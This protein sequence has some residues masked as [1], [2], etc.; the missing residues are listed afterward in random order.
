MSNR[1]IKFAQEFT[2]MPIGRYRADDKFSG[3]VFREDLLVPAL[4]NNNTVTLDLS[5][6][7]GFGSSFLEEAFSGIIRTKSFTLEELK[8]KLQIIC[9]D[10][11]MTIKQIWCY[12]EDADNR[13]EQSNNKSIEAEIQKFNG[14]KVIAN[15]INSIDDAIGFVEELIVDFDNITKVDLDGLVMALDRLKDK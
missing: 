15:T 8:R 6:V 11:P 9:A 5:N 1:L 13:L 4:K 2:D 12:I 7:Y 3:E 10:D 14:A